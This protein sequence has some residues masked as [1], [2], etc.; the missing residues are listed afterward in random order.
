MKAKIFI[1]IRQLS[2]SLSSSLIGNSIRHIWIIYRLQTKEK[3]KYVLQVHSID[4]KRYFIL[5]KHF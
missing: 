2:N 4:Y 3:F 5:K 1:L